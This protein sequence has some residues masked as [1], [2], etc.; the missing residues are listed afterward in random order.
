MIVTDR[1]STV[2]PE[3]KAAYEAMTKQ[4][5]KYEPN[6]KG[7]ITPAQSVEMCLKVIDGLTLKDSGAFLS[8]LGSK[9]WL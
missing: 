2:P 4:F 1:Y 6:F 9:R 8:H 3:G 7:P 5:Q